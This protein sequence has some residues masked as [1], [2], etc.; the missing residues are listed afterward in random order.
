MK[1]FDE[2]KEILETKVHGK[3]ITMETEL[4]GLGIDSLDLVEIIMDAE[5]KYGI[6]F[7]NDELSGFTTVGDVVETINKKL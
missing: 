4:K 5:E 2:F 3:E 1:Y 7:D 6:E